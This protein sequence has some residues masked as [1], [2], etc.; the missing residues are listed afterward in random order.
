MNLVSLLFLM[1]CGLTCLGT[2]MKQVGCNRLFHLVT[3]YVSLIRV[4]AIWAKSSNVNIHHNHLLRILRYAFKIDSKNT[5]CTVS[6]IIGRGW[7]KYR[8]LPVASRSI[9]C[10]CRRQR[11]IIDLRATDKSRYFART[12]INNCF[13]IHIQS[14][15]LLFYETL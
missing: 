9:I 4:T 11:K 5:L 2:T 7:A 12:E 13:I 1:F 3:F 10:R 14:F 6:S 15:V 8:D